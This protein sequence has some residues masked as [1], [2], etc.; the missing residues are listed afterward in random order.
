M[1][2]GKGM[3]TTR[4]ETTRPTVSAC[5]QTVTFP[6]QHFSTSST[7]FKRIMSEAVRYGG[8]FHRV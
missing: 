5:K 1:N 8:G 7:E 6:I 2:A 4:M 3:E